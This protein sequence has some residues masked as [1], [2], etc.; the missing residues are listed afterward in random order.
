MGALQGGVQ[1][2]LCD[3]F[4]SDMDA[5]REYC[6]QEEA[7]EDAV[8]FLAEGGGAGWALLGGLVAG[9]TAGSLAAT[10]SARAFLAVV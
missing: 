1:R 4:G 7:L 6:E 2:L 3:V 9:R 8:A 10:D 5:F